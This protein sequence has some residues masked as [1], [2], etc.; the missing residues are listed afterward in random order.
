MK[1]F[2]KNMLSSK[3]IEPL[4]PAPERFPSFNNVTEWMDQ[5]VAYYAQ[6]H[7]EKMDNL[8]NPS[9]GDYIPRT[10]TAG[11]SERYFKDNIEH[12]RDIKKQYP[13]AVENAKK[14]YLHYM[15]STVGAKED[16]PDGYLD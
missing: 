7:P 11:T 8:F 15:K 4:L 2:F 10:I 12:Y 5:K 3:Q 1:N 16:Y 6:Q 14:N 13:E 9:S